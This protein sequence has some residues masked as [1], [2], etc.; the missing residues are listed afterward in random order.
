MAK[1]VAGNKQIINYFNSSAF[2]SEHLATWRKQNGVTRGLQSAC[3]TRWFTFAKVCLS[4]DEHELGLLKCVEMAEDQSIS[5]PSM[6]QDVRQLVRTRNHFTANKALV[7]FLKPVVD[8]LARLEQD[9]TSLGDIWKEI[10]AVYLAINR[11]DIS[12]W[13]GYADFKKD[14]L[15]Y[16]HQRAQVYNEPIYTVAFFLSPAYCQ[17]AVSGIYPI[18][19]IKKMIVTIA[20]VWGYSK[21]DCINMK[22]QA[23]RYLDGSGLFPT[24]K[25]C[26]FCT[27]LF[28]SP[29]LL[30][31]TK[32][33]FRFPCTR[34]L[35]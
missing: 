20:H 32:L 14:C 3:V 29:I 4:V 18:K 13:P 6:P 15:P 30:I 22:D 2:F 5:T 33:L 26:E 25:E 10:C 16:I 19:Q 31:L 27:A 23:Q 21:P 35:N 34:L 9:S 24:T 1:V 7:L 12:V 11:I 8:A 17:V 28:F